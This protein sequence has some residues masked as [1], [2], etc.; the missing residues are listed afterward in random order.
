[1]NLNIY[2]DSETYHKLKEKVDNLNQ[3]I[4]REYGFKSPQITVSKYISN[5]IKE[6]LEEK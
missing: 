3:S 2:L 5:F 6:I 4:Q 1:M